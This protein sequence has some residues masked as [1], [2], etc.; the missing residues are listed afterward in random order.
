VWSKAGR[1][2]EVLHTIGNILMKISVNHVIKLH[3]ALLFTCV[4]LCV[5]II[6]SYNY[7][8]LWVFLVYV[9]Y[10]LYMNPCNYICILYVYVIYICFLKSSVCIY[11]NCM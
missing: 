5:Y 8:Y 10:H 2:V 3:A 11:F 1:F 4:F 6:S 9:Y 7:I